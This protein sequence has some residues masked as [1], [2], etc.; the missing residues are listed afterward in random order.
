MPMPAI[1]VVMG[2]LLCVLGAVSAAAA[3]SHGKSLGT[4][5]IPL[6]LGVVFVLLGA[7]SMA[8]P[9][10][11]KH[12][13]HALAMV[14]LLG[15]LAAVGSAAARWSVSSE[16]A[17]ASSGGMAIICALTLFFCIRSFIAARRAREALV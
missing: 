1:A 10:L 3:H 11:R 12:M 14:A 5:L 16:T 6:Y 2:I 9:T 7:V 15:F 4:A 17:K 13:M 8:K